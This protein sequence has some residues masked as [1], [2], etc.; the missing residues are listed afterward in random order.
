MRSFMNGLI[1]AV[2]AAMAGGRAAGQDAKSDPQAGTRPG[3]A[4][5]AKT[6]VMQSGGHDVLRLTAPAKT[7]GTPKDGWLHLWS[8]DHRADVW[9]VRG[10]KTVEDAAGRVAQEIKGEFKDFKA[11]GTTDLTVAGKPAKR[12]TGAGVEADDGDPGSA[13]VIVFKTGESIFVACAHGEHLAPAD[14][15]W[16]L[17]ILQTAQTP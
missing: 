4:E 12:L 17:T 16:M 10:A 6:F 5:D 14:G 8:Q 9:L 13:D 2:L 11:T 15:L 1:W 7:N 3:K